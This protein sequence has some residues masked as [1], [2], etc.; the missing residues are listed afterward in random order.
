MFY[1]YCQREIMFRYLWSETVNIRMPVFP[2]S[3]PNFLSIDQPH[4]SIKVC[5]SDV[6]ADWG[7]Q[8]HKGLQREIR[9][10]RQGELI[11]LLLCSQGAGYSHCNQCFLSPAP[12]DCTHP[13]HPGGPSEVC[14]EVLFLQIQGWKLTLS[15]EGKSI[16]VYEPIVRT[17]NFHCCTFL[18]YSD[19][20]STY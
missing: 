1:I 14:T 13:W 10:I 5:F 17:Q 20:E 16:W 19:F 3:W 2:H 18:L 8:V 4:V 12:Q 11:L 6:A 7:K 15:Y 9:L